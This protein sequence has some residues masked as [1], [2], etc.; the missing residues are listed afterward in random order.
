MGFLH[1]WRLGLLLE[2]FQYQAQWIVIES[3]TS[4]IGWGEVYNHRV[5]L[6]VGNYPAQGIISN[7]LELLAA[8]CTLKSFQQSIYQSAVLFH[9]DNTEAVFYIQRQGGMRSI[10]LMHEAAPIFRRAGIHLNLLSAVY[11]PATENVRADFLSRKTLD[12]EW[13]L[14]MDVCQTL[15]SCTFVPAVDLF[16]SRENGKL[17]QFISRNPCPESAGTDRF[18]FLGIFV[19]LRPFH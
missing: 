12:N 7:V 4:K 16:A 18:P 19:W 1:Q 13:S 10:N 3:N 17:L 9:L 15:V 8:F 2:H 5:A 6:V 11:T 14:V